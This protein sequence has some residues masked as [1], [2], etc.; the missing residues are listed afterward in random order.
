VG[1]CCDP[2]VYGVSVLKCETEV[3]TVSTLLVTPLCWYVARD[4]RSLGIGAFG[5]GDYG[6]VI[7]DVS[8]PDPGIIVLFAFVVAVGPCAFLDPVLPELKYMPAWTASFSDLVNPEF[9]SCVD[10]VT[11]VVAGAFVFEAVSDEPLR[12]RRTRLSGLV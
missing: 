2:V 5:F 10:V 3:Y 12:P 1:D 8:V 6:N 11:E 9:P 4:C 7:L